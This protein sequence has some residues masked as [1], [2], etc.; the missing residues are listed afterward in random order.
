MA[1]FYGSIQGQRGEAT[2]LGTKASGLHVT[3]ASWQGAASVVLYSSGDEDRARVRLHP[4]RGSGSNVLLYDGPVNGS[5]M[6]ELA[7]RL[8]IL[9]SVRDAIGL[10][11]SQVAEMEPG[12]S[13]TVELT[14]EE[15]KAIY[16]L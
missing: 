8:G 11:E 16:G 13:V 4:W 9:G 7:R 6:A 12:D 5:E 3:A 1:H 2:R 14:G 10:D 15:V